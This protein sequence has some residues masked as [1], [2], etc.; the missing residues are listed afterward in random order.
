[1]ADDAL[2][3]RNVLFDLPE[4]VQNMVY[5]HIHIRDWK[6]LKTCSKRLRLLARS[7][8]TTTT[9]LVLDEDTYERFVKPHTGKQD[10]DASAFARVTHLEVVGSLFRMSPVLARRIKHVLVTAPRDDS[11]DDESD[12]RDFFERLFHSRILESDVRAYVEREFPN[13]ST[14]WFRRRGD[15]RT[16]SSPLMVL[17]KPREYRFWDERFSDFR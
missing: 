10:I 3:P 5:G 15:D 1:M 13:A 2:D 4:D 7:K 16:W 12:A 17:L 9:R 14:A 6:T 11:V 8:T